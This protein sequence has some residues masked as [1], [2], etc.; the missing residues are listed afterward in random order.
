MDFGGAGLEYTS[1]VDGDWE[2]ELVG[3]GPLTFWE[4][5]SL[6][7]DDENRAHISFHN[8]NERSLYHGVRELTGWRLT[9]VDSGPEAGMFSSIAIRD[10][11]PIISYVVF[12][13]TGPTEVRLAT[14]ADDRWNVELI[15]VIDDLSTGLEYARN[16]TNLKLDGEGNPHVAYSG[17]STIKVASKVGDT[18]LIDVVDT[19]EKNTGSRFGQQVDLEQDGAG[20]WHL[21]SFDVTGSHPLNGKILYYRKIQ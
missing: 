21:A 20:N 19:I 12:F 15:D 14:F 10:G 5:L 9:R 3:S 17:E 11:N 1:L 2:V 4:G 13:E 18:W 16:A 8:T 7:Y 6:A